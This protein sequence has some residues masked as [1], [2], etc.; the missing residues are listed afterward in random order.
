MPSAD[1]PTADG[2]VPGSGAD[3]PTEVP[4]KGWWQILKRSW[5]E[6]KDDHVPLLAAGV[7]F[8]AFLSLFPALIA[9]V[10][11]YGLV[12][13][14]QE[15][16]AQISSFSDNLPEGAGTLITGQ[17]SQV[18]SSSSSALGVGLV[19]SLAVAL[20]SAS[21]GVANLIKAVNI[22]YDEDET[23]GFVVKRGLALLLTLGA[24]VFVV[25]AV[26]LIAV[27]P[28][29][30]GA[31][32]LGT[33]GQLL[34]QVL[35]WVGLVVAVMVALAVVYR[36]GPDRDAP[37]MRWVSLGAVIATVIW[38]IASVLF[39]FYVSNFGSYGKTYGSLAGV[40]V[41]L[42]WLWI[43]SYIILLGAEVNS[44]TEAQTAM[45]TT[46]GEPEPVGRRGAVK[47]DTRPEEAD[48]RTS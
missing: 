31:V 46:K 36:V 8:F 37:K 18:A 23:R 34:V 24:I 14:P 11:V 47:A 22:A 27:V 35:R 48:Q 30:A 13:S 7:A 17:L 21:T 1:G 32:G 45:D 4:A 29:V 38:I 15:I 16:E 2:T 25:V 44:E 42:F 40:V 39:S 3:K 9:T 19:I 33:G 26:A 12:K 43:T 5:A 28:Q 6:A 10:L 41:L 20:W